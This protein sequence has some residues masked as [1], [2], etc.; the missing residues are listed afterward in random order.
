MALG[1]TFFFYFP[2]LFFVFLESRY[3]S[4]SRY[5]SVRTVCISLFLVQLQIESFVTCDRHP[6]FP[7]EIYTTARRLESIDQSGKAGRLMIRATGRTYFRSPTLTSTVLILL[8]EPG[9]VCETL[10]VGQSA[11]GSC[12]STIVTGTPIWIFD[13]SVCHFCRPWRLGR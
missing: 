6:R 3:C 9:K 7:V 4:L 8:S 11:R 12:G 10:P 5:V 13:A 1:L 2:S